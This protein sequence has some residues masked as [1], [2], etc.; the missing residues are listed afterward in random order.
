LRA[1][2]AAPLLAACD[3]ALASLVRAIEPSAVVGIGR[4]AETRARAVVGGRVP[5]GFM[6]HPSPANPTAN[7]DWPALAESALAPW[8]PS[9]PG[10]S[11]Q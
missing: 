4:Y 7:R 5:V 8:L 6:H 3:A 10:M 1:A 9:L 2:E 11:A